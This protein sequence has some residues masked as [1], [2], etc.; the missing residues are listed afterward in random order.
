MSNLQKKSR[1]NH[2]KIEPKYRFDPNQVHSPSFHPH[3]FPKKQKN[4]GFGTI[5]FWSKC[6]RLLYSERWVISVKFR[7][8][9]VSFENI[10]LTWID[11]EPIGLTKL[12][13]AILS[14]HIKQ[15]SSVFV[16]SL[17]CFRRKWKWVGFQRNRL[18]IDVYSEPKWSMDRNQPHFPFSRSNKIQI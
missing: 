18:K 9:Q 12:M 3:N 4:I 16:S 14:I 1:K 8:F 15:V 5:N 2:V 17:L 6:L 7:S 10:G 11:L 13:L